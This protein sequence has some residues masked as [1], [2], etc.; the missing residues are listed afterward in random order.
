MHRG[1]ISCA[2]ELAL[3]E[4][5]DKFIRFVL[6]MVVVLQSHGVEPLLVP[7]SG[8]LLFR[9]EVGGVLE[10]VLKGL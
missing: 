1:A 9:W 3:G 5:S 6:Q 8:A 2:L 4:D 10:H 7:R